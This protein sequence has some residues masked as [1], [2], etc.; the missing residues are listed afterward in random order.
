MTDLELI[1]LI[2]HLDSVLPSEGA[3]VKTAAFGEVALYANK[4]GYLRLGIEL[5]KCA[6]KETNDGSGVGHLFSND[7]DIVLD[8]LATSE[9]EFKLLTS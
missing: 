9:E 8:S 5:M 3:V 4:I 1:R 6:F 2:R 7:S